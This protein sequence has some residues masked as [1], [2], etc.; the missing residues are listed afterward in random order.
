MNAPQHILCL[1]GYRQCTKT[2]KTPKDH[3]FNISAET[4]QPVLVCN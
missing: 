2:V 1:T 4:R 3:Q